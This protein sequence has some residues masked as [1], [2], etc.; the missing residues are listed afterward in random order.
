MPAF[1]SEYFK[2]GNTVSDKNNGEPLRLL[3]GLSRNPCAGG[4]SQWYEP[5]E[6]DHDQRPYGQGLVVASVG[7]WPWLAGWDLPAVAVV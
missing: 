5:L 1:I 7:R 6:L 2:S 3:F 4:M